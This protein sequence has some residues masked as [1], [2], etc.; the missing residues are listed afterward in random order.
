MSKQVNG[1]SRTQIILHWAIFALV[2]FQFVGNSAIVE[3]NKLVAD[4][5]QTD[6]IPVLVRGHVLLGILTLLLTLW[7]VG[8]RLTRGAPALPAEESAALQMVAKLAHLT[9]YAG[10]I[11]MPVSGVA[12]WFGNVELAGT[13]HAIFRFVF[14]AAIA[15]HVVGALYQQYVLKT[16]LINRMMKAG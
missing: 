12:A 4:G 13:V 11:I 7:R 5:L 15:L 3:F 14:L 2:A 9:L 6:T 8:L 10:L 16:G 1:Y